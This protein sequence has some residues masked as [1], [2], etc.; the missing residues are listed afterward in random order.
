MTLNFYT[1]HVPVYC[2][3]VEAEIKISITF[4]IKEERRG[5]ARHDE[6]FVSVS[7]R[8]CVALATLGNTFT[9]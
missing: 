5:G 2:H 4:S 7:A 9:A 8:A 1:F 6:T 3:Y